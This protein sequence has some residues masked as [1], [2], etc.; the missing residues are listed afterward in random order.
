MMVLYC[1][2]NQTIKQSAYRI[3]FKPFKKLMDAVNISLPLIFSHQRSKTFCIKSTNFT[4]CN[5]EIHY[6]AKSIYKIK[7]KSIVHL[8]PK[9]TS[10]FFIIFSGRSKQLVMAFACVT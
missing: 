3:L 2:L 9:P 6:R 1:S 10:L 7:K 4:G 8:I 5:I